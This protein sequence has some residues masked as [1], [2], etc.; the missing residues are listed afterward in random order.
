MVMSVVMS[1][2]HMSYIPT[3]FINY[4]AEWVRVQA[5]GAGAH[6]R[7]A[8]AQR[9]ARFYIEL[10]L[11]IRFDLEQEVDKPSLPSA[12]VNPTRSRN[13][14]PVSLCLF[15]WNGRDSQYGRSED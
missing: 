12:S 8:A 5:A 7:A 9:A 6:T 11:F 3:G 1:V 13:R 15:L 10:T 14:K 2:V 4:H